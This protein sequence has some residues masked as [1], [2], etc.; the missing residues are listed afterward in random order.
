MQRDVV[1][2]DPQWFK[3]LRDIVERELAIATLMEGEL[4]GS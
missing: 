3:E 1:N 2:I 4:F